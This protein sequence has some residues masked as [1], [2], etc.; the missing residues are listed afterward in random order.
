MLST[1]KLLSVGYASSEALAAYIVM[2]RT[3]GI[4]K[5]L[6]KVC[7]EELSRRRKLGEDFDYETFIEEKVKTIPKLK[8]INLPQMNKKFKI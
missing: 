1:S 5:E 6:A 8:N 4:N 3:L 2:Y 7:M